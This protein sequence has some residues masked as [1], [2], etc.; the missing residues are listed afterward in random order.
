MRGC[1]FAN[2]MVA[3]LSMHPHNVFCSEPGPSSSAQRVR[4]DLYVSAS[5]PESQPLT[6]APALLPAIQSPP[7]QRDTQ[8]DR[9]QT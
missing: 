4:D 2:C 5:V 7:V 1:W 6:R 9:V 3:S 8:Q